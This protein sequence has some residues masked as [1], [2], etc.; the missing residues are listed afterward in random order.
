MRVDVL[1][2]RV[3]LQMSE[4]KVKVIRECAY[5]F[6]MK[7]T[8]PHR[9][10]LQNSAASSTACIVRMS[11]S[12]TSNTRRSRTTTSVSS[13]NSA[14]KL[15]HTAFATA[16]AIGYRGSSLVSLNEVGTYLKRCANFQEALENCDK[17]LIESAASQ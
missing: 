9:L 15:V 16:S 4:E 7:L 13:A 1:H 6:S 2:S 14:T 12:Q 3:S 17:L 5:K 8:Y 10:M 11:D